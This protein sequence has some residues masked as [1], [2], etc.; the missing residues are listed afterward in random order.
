MISANFSCIYLT[1]ASTKEKGKG[2]RKDQAERKKS[3]LDKSGEV[4]RKGERINRTKR[5]G[6]KIELMKTRKREL[7]EAEARLGSREGM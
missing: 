7:T 1:L 5:D 2:A 4:R 6:G 3:G